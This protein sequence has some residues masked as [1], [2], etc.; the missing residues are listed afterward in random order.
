M[1]IEKMYLHMLSF[2]VTGIY[3]VG[4]EFFYIR[5]LISYAIQ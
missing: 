4:I 5:I 3:I 1:L 2:L